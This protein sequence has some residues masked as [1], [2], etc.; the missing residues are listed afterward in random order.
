MRRRLFRRDDGAA[1]DDVGCSGC[2]SG[3]TPASSKNRPGEKQTAAN[4]FRRCTRRC[5]CCHPGRVSERARPHLSRPARAHPDRL[6]R[7][8]LH[9][10]AWTHRGA[11]AQRSLGPER[12][13]RELPGAGGNIGAAA[14]AQAA[15]DGYSLHFG[16][17]TLGVNVTIAPYQNFDPV[18]DFEP[19]ILA[20]TATDV[21]VVPV[22]S[23][24]QTLRQLI[25]YA[26]DR[27]G[28]S[29]IAPWGGN[30]LHL[31]TVQF[32][33][34]SGVKLQHVPY[35]GFAQATT[36]LVAGRIALWIPTLGGSIGNIEG[37]KMRALAISGPA[38]AA[39]LPDVPTFEEQGFEFGESSWYAMFAP[40]GTQK[41]I[42]AKVNLDIERVLALPD[43]KEKGVTLG[44]RFVGGPSEKLGEFLKTRSPSGPTRRSAARS[45]DRSHRASDEIDELGNAR[46]LGGFL[47]RCPPPRSP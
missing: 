11:E 30:Q 37:G 15:P 18:R 34:I 1:A 31:S 38:R 3:R 26:K 17:Q 10:H 12:G 33:G 41:D 45:S 6:P 19:I 28:E 16:A 5:R 20:G 46:V 32:S 4:A 7:R 14:A 22:S 21:L 44:Y 2:G 29:T 42:I 39:A 13:D 23:P 9:R 36:D 8:R 24:F 43:V 40:K 25:D 27:P 47:A 35:T